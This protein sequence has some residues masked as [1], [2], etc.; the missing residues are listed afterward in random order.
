MRS[1]ENL[2]GWGSGTPIRRGG[3]T[4]PRELGPRS[5]GAHRPS[6]QAAP[7]S[8]EGCLQPT[9]TLEVSSGDTDKQLLKKTN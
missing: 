1:E 5:L 7:W 9:V 8:P 6:G 4:G 2:L 3:C